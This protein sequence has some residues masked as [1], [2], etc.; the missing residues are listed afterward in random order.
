MT[1]LSLVLPI[2]RQPDK[3][4][5]P[6]INTALTT[7][8]NWANGNIDSSNIKP[9]SLGGAS[10]A[11]GLNG[12]IS[13]E[14]IKPPTAQTAF[15][16]NAKHLPSAT[17]P[18]FV[19][20]SYA[21][22]RVPPIIEAKV[23]VGDTQIAKVAIVAEEAERYFTTPFICRAGEEWQLLCVGTWGLTAS[24]TEL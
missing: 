18:V 24:Y 9:E 17:R 6:K 19:L 14:S 2:L 5:D 7:M 3:T 4:E 20:L 8:Q 13:G 15:S 10:F 23:L 1:L 12:V 21:S 22:P 11:K 16:I